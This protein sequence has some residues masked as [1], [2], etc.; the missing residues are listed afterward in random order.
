MKTIFL[1]PLILIIL[2]FKIP[3]HSKKI[4]APDADT[5]I[6]HLLDGLVNEWPIEKF[7]EDKST[8]IKYSV[9]NDAQNLYVAMIIPQFPTQMKMMRQGM[10]LFIDLKGKKKE[11]RGIEFPVRSETTGFSGGP[12]FTN[13]NQS[14][15]QQTKENSER[16]ID[17]AAIRS[18]Y[19]LNLFALKLFGFNDDAEPAKQ[20]LTMEGSANIGFSW[21]SSDVMYVEYTIPFAI[22]DKGSLN[23]KI[24]SIGWKLNGMDA[25]GSGVP[26]AST[27]RVV[28][29]S[30][31][32]RNIG[33]SGPTTTNSMVNGPSQ[34]DREAIM[35][36][37]YIW[38]KYTINFPSN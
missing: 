10:E 21:D 5:A 24:I 26:V 32:S 18:R 15:S 33:R 20:G 12:G 38:T 16:V 13:T 36:E 23:Q 8:S 34:Q 7:E 37:Q 17:K 29:S 14:T 31:G 30:A 22:L 6:I 19:A 11:A 35:K 3:G 25:S 9:D 28:S 2:S 1:L 27:S 4:S